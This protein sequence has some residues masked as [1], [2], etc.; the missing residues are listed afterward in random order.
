[1]TR[2]RLLSDRGALSLDG[3]ALLY[4]MRLPERD[5]DRTSIGPP[6]AAMR[7]LLA[8]LR[9]RPKAALHPSLETRREELVAEC[10]KR[11]YLNLG[12]E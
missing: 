6:V 11:V 8:G 4:W 7:R 9:E 12:A 2:A 10:K 1:V 5:R 3:R